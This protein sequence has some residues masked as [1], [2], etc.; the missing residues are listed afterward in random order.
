MAYCILVSTVV[1]CLVVVVVGLVKL[2]KNAFPSPEPM[3]EDEETAR[4]QAIT[5]RHVEEQ[6]TL[7]RSPSRRA[8]GRDH[9][10]GA[11]KASSPTDSANI[12]GPS[13]RC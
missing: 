1:F 3:D 7:F 6:V 8:C 10:K 5:R 4:R 11:S 13:S 2:Y 9:S 12:A